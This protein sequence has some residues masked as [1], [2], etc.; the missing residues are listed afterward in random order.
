DD[1]LVLAGRAERQRR[2][3]SFLRRQHLR[4]LLGEDE[5]GDEGIAGVGQAEGGV[6]FHLGVVVL[7]CLPQRLQ[8]VRHGNPHQGAGGG[9]ADLV[10][11]AVQQRHQL[12]QRRTV[13]EIAQPLQRRQGEVHPVALALLLLRLGGGGQRQERGERRRGTVPRHGP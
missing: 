5:R 1:E 12:G 13:A 4:R 11:L 7:Q 3:E 2:D 9:L 8:V 6:V 10:V